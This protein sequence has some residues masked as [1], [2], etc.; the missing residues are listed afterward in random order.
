[1]A[2]RRRQAEHRRSNPECGWGRR[3]VCEVSVHEVF[4]DKDRLTGA[5][6]VFGEVI[7][8]GT[9]VLWACD[10]RPIISRSK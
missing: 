1:M 5:D 10:R 2:G 9:R 7:A 3:P 6:D 4:A 8:G